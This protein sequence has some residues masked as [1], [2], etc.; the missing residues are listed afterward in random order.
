MD[1]GRHY[2]NVRVDGLLGI[3]VCKACC[4]EEKVGD[5]EKHLVVLST[6]GRRVSK[7]EGHVG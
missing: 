4:L 6:V 7:E 5:C 1:C 3:L 2:G